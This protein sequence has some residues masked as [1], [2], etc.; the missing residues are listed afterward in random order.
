MTAVALTP[1]V[2]DDAIAE[3]GLPA[4]VRHVFRTLAP[5]IDW[6]TGE[7]PAKRAP[8]LTELQRRTGHGRRTVREALFRLQEDGWVSRQPPPEEKS[9]REHAKT[10]TW[11]H[12]PGSALADQVRARLK[13]PDHVAR[14]RMHRE[15][16]ERWRDGASAE[17]PDWA[18]DPGLVA[19]AAQTLAQVTGH[20]VDETTAAAAVA[21]ILGGHHRGYFK[22]GPPQY[23]VAAIKKN[24][25]RFLPTPE[26]PRHQAPA[27]APPPEIAVVGAAQAKRLLGLR[28]A[29]VPP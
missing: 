19:L 28:P 12:L 27:A 7:I 9:R 8:S 5:R 16:W 13:G 17:A 20:Q 3:T 6:K 21:T 26:P 10:R 25:R 23:L 29:T 14:R 1:A 15:R 4:P 24:P 2:L 18:A 11:L 22:A